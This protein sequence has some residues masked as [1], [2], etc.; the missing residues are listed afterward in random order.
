MPLTHLCQIAYIFFNFL[1]HLLFIYHKMQITIKQDSYTKA[2]NESGEEAQ[3]ETMRLKDI[4]L[5]QS[6]N[7]VN[8][9]S[10]ARIKRK[11]KD[12]EGKLKCLC[13]SLLY[14]NSVVTSLHVIHQACT[15]TK[16]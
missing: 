9:N 11:V 10:K 3:K 12:N 5:P 16:K 15:L 13:T 14:K 4:G 6:K 7:N 2:L 8:S 1:P